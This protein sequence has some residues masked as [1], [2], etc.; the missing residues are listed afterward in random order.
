MEWKDIKNENRFSR[1]GMMPKERDKLLACIRDKGFDSA[2]KTMLNPYN[3]WKRLVYYS[4][5]AFIRNKITG[6]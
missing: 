2:V 3:D 6:Q 5:P 1:G 4:L